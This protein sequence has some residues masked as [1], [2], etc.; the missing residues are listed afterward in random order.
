MLL[1]AVGR[2]TDQRVAPWY[3]ADMSVQEPRE[4]SPSRHHGNLSPG[5]FL[6]ALLGVLALA[7][8]LGTNGLTYW[9]SV[10]DQHLVVEAMGNRCSV[11][12]ADQALP[13]TVS[14]SPQ[15]RFSTTQV[16]IPDR[17]ILVNGLASLAAA[18]RRGEDHQVHTHPGD[19]RRSYYHFNPFRASLVARS[20]GTELRLEVNVPDATIEAWQG[21]EKLAAIEVKPPWARLTAAPLLAAAASAWLLVLALGG[22][23]GKDDRERSEEGLEQQGRSWP[24]AARWWEPMLAGMAGAFVTAA[25]LW[26]TVDAM[27]GFGD[28]MNY[29]MQARIFASGLAWTLEPPLPEFFRVGWMDMFGSDGRVWGFHPPG[30]SLHLALGWLVGCYWITVPVVGGLLL[31]V[32]YLLALEVFGNRRIALLHVAVLGSSHY[33]LALAAS[34]MAHA[35][36][37]L[38]L[39]LLY[40]FGIRFV[41]RAHSSDLLLAA[42]ASGAAFTVRPISALLAT[43]PLVLVMVVKHGRRRWRPMAGAAIVGLVAAAVVPTYTWFCAGRFTV[44]YAVKGPEASRTLSSRLARPLDEH[45]A[46]L[47]RNCN[48][49]Q[50]RVH[51]GGIIGNAVL[52]FVPLLAWRRQQARRWLALAG[53][54]LVLVVVMHS[55]LHWYGWKWEPRMLY[56]VV[57]L[58]FLVST[59]G[60]ATLLTVT[61]TKPRLRFAFRIAL[62]L[63]L[64]AA[65]LIDLPHRF[66]TEYRRYNQA[67]TGVMSKLRHGA[68]DGSVIFFD[69]ERQLACYTP[70]NTPSF[71][72]DPLFVRHR[73]ELL[74]YRLL[75][76][77]PERRAYFTPDGD[78]LQEKDN[79]YRR[80]LAALSEALELHQTT[81]PIVVVPWLHVAPSPMLD[82]LP[83]G[84]LDSGE[85]LA[86]AVQDDS[87]HDQPRLVVLLAGSADLAAVLDVLF[88]TSVPDA[89]PFE[90]RIELRLVGERRPETAHLNPGLLMTCHE[91][92]TWSGP[93][94][95][96]RIVTSTDIDLCPGE[97]RSMTWHALLDVEARREVRFSLESDDGSAVFLDGEMVLDNNLH[98]TH[99]VESRSADVTLEPGRHELLV[100]YFNGPGEAVLRATVALDGGPPQPLT[101]AVFGPKSYL[102]QPTLAGAFE[103][104]E[105]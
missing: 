59:G 12:G 8:G 78:E 75:A 35:T 22:R 39:S 56:D 9:V 67:P 80:D 19:Q 64:G 60:L 42:L 14:L 34:F 74:D 30:N 90:T 28:E 92:T 85:F 83:A 94:L 89:P 99:G 76:R 62:A 82:R 69:S 101:L 70:F 68:L 100:K 91:G 16:L 29:L 58:A 95:A 50:H 2:L 6:A 55:L 15:S 52:L 84:L 88:D 38:C 4:G 26:S 7:F 65:I 93:V 45:L 66:A 98:S 10:E 57:F 32:Q 79:F 103:K 48:E 102:L 43:V 87:A 71:D 13:I 21:Q 1:K 73:G 54:S 27:P 5:P 31:A 11:A 61:E 63:S 36:S 53:G 24:V 97:D 17:G 105:P 44:P 18:F 81:S 23:S 72:G 3:A 51:S 77:F 40:L 86:R 46:N 25:I 49:L 20:G 41:R 47:Y 96:R 37:M 104:A 33:V